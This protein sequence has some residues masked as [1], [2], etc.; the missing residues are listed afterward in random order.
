MVLNG[1]IHEAYAVWCSTP[2][3]MILLIKDA[4][5]Q[6]VFGAEH[7]ISTCRRKSIAF[8]ESDQAKFCAIPAG[9]VSPRSPR[10]QC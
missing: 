5:T 2:I 4:K 7:E 10:A 8:L 1:A 3:E 6:F 9:I